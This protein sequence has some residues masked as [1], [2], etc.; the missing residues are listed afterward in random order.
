MPTL[1]A[2]GH[3]S[4]ARRRAAP[5]EGDKLL[6]ELEP[7]SLACRREGSA[8]RVS[9]GIRVTQRRQ[10]GESRLHLP[11]LR[12]Q[13]ARSAGAP[14]AASLDAKAGGR[15]CGQPEHSTNGPGHAEFGGSVVRVPPGQ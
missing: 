15:R 10:G 13:R 5:P 9:G 11:S 8:S 12:E 6:V 3:A 1:L 4:E 14:F 2:E 7:G